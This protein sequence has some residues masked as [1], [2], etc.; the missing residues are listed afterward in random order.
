MNPISVINAIVAGNPF[1]IPPMSWP[2]YNQLLTQ[3][4]IARFINLDVSLIS[5]S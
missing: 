4:R 3:T 1:K 5:F 2:E